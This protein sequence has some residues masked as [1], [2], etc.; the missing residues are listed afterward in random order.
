MALT[1][2][3]RGRRTIGIPDR[4]RNFKNATT[5]S[6]ESNG[7]CPPICPG[8]KIIQSRIVI[9]RTSL[10]NRCTLHT[11][12]MTLAVLTFAG[13]I[14]HVAFV[15]RIGP[16]S[17]IKSVACAG[18]RDQWQGG[19]LKLSSSSRS[20]FGYDSHSK[21]S[22]RMNLGPILS[23]APSM[24]SSSPSLFMSQSSDTEVR[25]IEGKPA[26]PG[27]DEN[28]W[29]T[30]LAAFQMYKAAYGDLKVPS[31]FVVPAIAPW[32]GKDQI[33]LCN[34]QMNS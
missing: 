23:T 16:N 1:E 8:A 11:C 13:A 32:P 25:R 20:C 22:P 10:Q 3:V 29:R 27:E 5:S 28:E 15:T 4:P 34:I 7:R 18:H 21:N 14:R 33:L 9:C 26:S 24:R 12:M 6:I 30:I 17:L 31:R 2:R 19:I